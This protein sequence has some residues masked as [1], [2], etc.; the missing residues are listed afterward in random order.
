MPRPRPRAKAL[1]AAAGGS[2]DVE[3]ALP[4]LTHPERVIDA[5]TGLTKL[6][7]ARWY[8]LAAERYF[9]AEQGKAWVA[10]IGAMFASMARISVEP[11]WVGLLDFESRF[12]GAIEAVSS[13]R[14]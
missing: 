5:S 10:Q 7:L 6:D 3:G 8:A 1:E 2:V 9:G 14:S 4:K 13:R 12:P 11:E